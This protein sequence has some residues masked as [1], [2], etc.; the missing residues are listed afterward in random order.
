MPP[1]RARSIFYHK[2]GKVES[3]FVDVIDFD[4]KIKKFIVEFV[5]PGESTSSIGRRVNKI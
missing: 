3:I 5:M 1:L 4:T 2:N